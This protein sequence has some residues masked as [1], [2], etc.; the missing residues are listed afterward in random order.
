M[1]LGNELP[2]TSDTVENITLGSYSS[3]V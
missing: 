3:P 1:Q 2:Y